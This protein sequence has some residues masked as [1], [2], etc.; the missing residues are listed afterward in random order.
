M[1]RR[2]APEVYRAEQ[3]LG[4]VTAAATR[5]A[6]T[7]VADVA[8]AHGCSPAQVYKLLRRTRDALLPAPPGPQ[9][10]ARPVVTRST[11]APAPK[12]D[13]RALLAVLTSQHVSVRG[14]QQVFAALH[15]P[16][17]TRQHVVDARRA[18][19]RASRRILARAREQVRARL[20]CLAGDDIFFHR[21]AVKVLME[22]ASGAVLDV[23]RW[24][25]REA[26]D[27]RLWLEDW[28]ALRLFVSD[29]GTD[30]TGAAR[31]ARL[32]HQADLFHERKWWHEQVFMPL[33]RREQKAAAAVLR[34]WDRATRVEGP[35]RRLGPEAIERAEAA[36]AR[37]EEE[38][39]AA[40]RAEELLRT[41]FEP[42]DPCGARWSDEAIEDV[43]AAVCEHLVSVPQD[44][45]FAAWMHVY[46]HRARW[47]AHR[48][49]WESVEVEL[50]PGSRW[51]RD[52][53][54]DAFIEL[55]TTERRLRD[56]TEWA[57]ARAAQ[58]RLATL[59]DELA[60]AC[61]NA[62]RVERAVR[63]LLCRPR[64]SSSLVEAFNSS[65]RVLQMKHRN[66]S[67]DLMSL[68][69]LAWNLRVRKEGRRRG[70]SPFEQLGVEFASD[71]RPWYEVLI[72]EMDQP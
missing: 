7:T 37:A 40:V 69:A 41:L 64:R 46:T 1:Y 27:W 38:F 43:L 36:R 2:I 14:T 35:G 58:V 28:P 50:A 4:V 13:H 55:H 47:C 45:S 48:V 72:E 30:L 5:D 24:P 54:L 51:T 25:W 29:L 26:E 3:R 59:R 19:G 62:K 52:D 21:S 68:H 8:S 9:P 53:V 39:F 6:D 67:D 60:S 34:A 22:P 71:H 17:P 56:A 33:S 15:L 61:Q 23:M 57:I 31:R 65:L 42:L 10:A 12:V 63:S 20:T 66:V 32:V 11:A 16:V 49:L 18:M 70:R 44:V